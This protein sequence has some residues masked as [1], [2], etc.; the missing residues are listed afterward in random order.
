MRVGQ[1]K[2]L[3]RALTKQY[4]GGANV[5]FANQSRTAKQKEPLVVLT[6]G[7]VHRPQAPNYT[8]VDG[9]VVGHYL[10]RFSIT[11]DLFTNGS[12]SMKYQGR[13]WHTRI[14]RWTICCP[15]PTSSI[16]S[17]PSNGAIRTM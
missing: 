15:L 4:F 16:P 2:E 13:S 10:S 11:V 1:A 17:I 12:S 5:V 3:F 14:T 9:E 7:N 8:F 6:P